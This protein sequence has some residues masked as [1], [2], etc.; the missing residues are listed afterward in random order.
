MRRT[1]KQSASGFSLIELLIAMA[2]GLIVLGGAVSMYSGGTSA[3]WTVTQ[4]AE[5]Q[6]DSRAAYDLMTQDISLAGAGLPSGGLAIATGGAT[7]PKYGCDVVSLTCHLGATNTA[8]IAFPQTPAPV[9]NQMYW[10]IP[11]YQSGPTLNAAIGPTDVITTV[12]TDNVL[13]LQ[14]YYVQFNDKYGNS[15]NLIYPA[16]APLPAPQQLSA[17]GTALQVGDLVLFQYGTY[18]AIAEVTAAPGAAS[19]SPYNVSFAAGDLLGLNQNAATNNLPYLVSQ[20]LAAAVCTLGVPPSGVNLNSITATR[21]WMVTYYIDNT[22]TAPKLMRL[23]NARQPVPVADNVENLQFT[24]DTFTS[25]GTL[26]TQS[27]NAGGSANYNLIRTINLA[28][29]SLRSQGNG[30]QAYQGTAKGYQGIDMQTSISARNLSFS[31]RY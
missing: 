19:A 31:E 8:A 9:V 7:L 13:L 2:V 27:G 29:L 28:H 1:S 23:V 10:L 24:Y 20:C 30:V 25:A 14:D 3:T 15:V 17:T 21:L 22:G 16:P 4:R 12:Y 18:S 5:M 11:G 6:Q 26:L